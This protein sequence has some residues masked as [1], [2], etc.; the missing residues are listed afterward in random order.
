MS[1]NTFDIYKM[2]SHCKVTRWL[3]PDGKCMLCSATPQ[4]EP[5][6]KIYTRKELVMMETS[7]YDFH[8]ILYI[9]SIKNISFNVPHV[10]TIAT[11]QY[12]NTAPKKLNFCGYFHDVLCCSNYVELVVASFAH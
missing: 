2:V 6:A 9:P 10:C 1:Y 3:P 11:H 4:T 5:K 7:I 12:E 8:T